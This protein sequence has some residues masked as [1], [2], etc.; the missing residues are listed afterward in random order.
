MIKKL[1]KSSAGIWTLSLL[2][3]LYIRLVHRTSSWTLKNFHIPKKYLDANKPFLTCFWHGRLLMLPYGWN[4]IDHGKNN[5]FFMLISNHA[6]GRLISKT[7]H[8]FGIKT[9][10][11]STNRG[12][13]DALRQIIKTARQNHTVGITP[14]GP[15]GPYDSVS[16]GTI[17]ISE[18][19]KLDILPITFSTSRAKIFRSWDKFF[20]PLP[21]SKGAIL[22]GEPVTINAKDPLEE[23][24]KKVQ[25]ALKM[26]RE[27]AD[28]CVGGPQ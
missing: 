15:R 17:K 22:W 23:N 7:V 5:P 16:E 25:N 18:L 11:G 28:R 1:L 21:F 9:I 10:A 6:D 12:G 27:E 3:S 19:C 13:S 4:K 8:W 14:D 2:A 24:Q 26:L 20:L